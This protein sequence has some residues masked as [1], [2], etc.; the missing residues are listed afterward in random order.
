M[1]EVSVREFSETVGTPIDR[2]L[3]QLSEAGLPHAAEAD[4][5]SDQDKERLLS[6]LRRVHGK[7]DGSPG[8]SSPRKKI[9]LKRRQ[10]S[11]IS[12]A[13]SPR[14]ARGVGGGRV[15]ARKRTVKVDVLRSRTYARPAD[16][17]AGPT[18]EVL[19]EQ[20]A[21]KSHL[22]EEARAHRRTLDE[23]LRAGNEARAAEEVRRRRERELAE[24]KARE[25]SVRAEEAAASE[26]TRRQVP[27]RRRNRRTGPGGRIGAGSA[28]VRGGPE[29]VGPERVS[30]ER[31][32]GTRGTRSTKG[33]G[34]AA[35]AL[36]SERT[37]PVAPPAPAPESRRH[38]DPAHLRT[39]DRTRG[40]G[41]QRAGDH[42]R[43]RART[44]DVHQG[45]RGSQDA[46]ESRLHGDHQPDPR[47]GYGYPR[48]GGDGSYRP[49]AQPECAGRRGHRGRPDGRR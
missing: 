36:G 2:L 3:V 35:R 48:G 11:E 15:A 6:Y 26:A 10:V 29:G 21:A 13:P 41:G 17:P 18:V 31:A 44:R 39:P 9:T 25:E 43:G 7:D 14:E 49:A 42:H 12:V 28:R 45:R 19:R 20:E 5:L 34:G 23:R 37:A 1:A 47:P 16:E 38:P 46:D 33:S 30:K 27:R 4:L 32:E 22:V 40:P 24:A 8:W